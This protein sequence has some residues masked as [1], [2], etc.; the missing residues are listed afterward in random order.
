MSLSVRSQFPASPV[1]CIQEPESYIGPVTLV[2]LAYQGFFEKLGIPSFAGLIEAYN[3]QRVT[4]KIIIEAAIASCILSQKLNLPE[5]RG[6]IND[7]YQ[8]L[9]ALQGH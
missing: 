9:K 8:E 1:K 6:Y 7:M 2:Q 5:N 4:P 3:D